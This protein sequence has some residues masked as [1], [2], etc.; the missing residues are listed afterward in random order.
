MSAQIPAHIG[1]AMLVLR[2]HAPLGPPIEV[3]SNDL[4]LRELAQFEAAAT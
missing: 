1:A 2:D 3:F 4:R